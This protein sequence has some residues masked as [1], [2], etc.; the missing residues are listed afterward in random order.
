MK[1]TV[2]LILMTC[3]SLLAVQAMAGVTGPRPVPAVPEPSSLLAMGT[4]IVG[5]VA[6]IRRKLL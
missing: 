2:T 5:L 6:V 4:G 1:R 3:L